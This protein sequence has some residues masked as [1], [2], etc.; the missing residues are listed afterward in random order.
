M[1]TRNAKRLKRAFRRKDE[2]IPSKIKNLG[3][4]AISANAM[5]KLSNGGEFG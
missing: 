4:Y 1:I 3:L 5:F 2:K